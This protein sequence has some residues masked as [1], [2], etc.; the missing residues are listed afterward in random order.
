M[1]KSRNPEEKW[2][3]L[4]MQYYHAGVEFGK[5][6]YYFD[7]LGMRSNLFD[8]NLLVLVEAEKTLVKK[9]FQPSELDAF[10]ERGYQGM[11]DD[12]LIGA[13]KNEFDK[14]EIAVLEKGEKPTMYAT[15]LA[16]HLGLL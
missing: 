10:T 7:Y 15:E 11:L 3:G 4:I 16:N 13:G 2:L 12:G 5:D 9:G 14:L 6:Y 8:E 1:F